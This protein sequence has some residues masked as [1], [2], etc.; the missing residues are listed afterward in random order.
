MSEAKAELMN[1]MYIRHMT[2]AGA[3]RFLSG[4]MQNTVDANCKNC[5][6][7]WYEFPMAFRQDEYCS[8][9]CRKALGLD[10]V[11]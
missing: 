11:K 9:N 3:D 6:R 8:D 10:L 7:S 2:H 1:D 5:R 4:S